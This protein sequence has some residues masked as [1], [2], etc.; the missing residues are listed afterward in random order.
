MRRWPDVLPTPSFPGFG[1]TPYDAV[2]R[3]DMEVG[4]ARVR[5]TT[6]AAADKIS[7][8]WIFSDAEMAAFRAWFEDKPVSVAGDS[9][10][11]RGWSKVEATITIA[12]ETGPDGCLATR[13]D[14]TAA[15]GG[16]RVSKSFPD[17]ARNTVAVVVW[18]SLAAAGSNFARIRWGDRDGVAKN[19]TINLA[20]GSIVDAGGVPVSVT[21]RGDGY[22]RV[23][24]DVSTGVGDGDPW[25]SLIVMADA[26]TESFGGSG[27]AIDVC[28]VMV[29]EQTG[30]DLF[31]RS[32]A[33]GRALGAAG[34]SAWVE[35]PIA[36]GGG[37]SF[38]ETRFV[39]PWSATGGAG[40]EWSVT[41]TVE[42]R[43][44]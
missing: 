27:C 7:C 29:R 22:W 1:L 4:L 2:L 35:M 10:D 36:T 37:F 20:T 32:G 34:G 8:A 43:N 11:L 38:V 30:F 3:T 12:P 25:L 33:D 23:R 42:S 14:Q 44:A 13:I 6:M 41:A 15:V 28:E 18:A 31:V 39:G 9:D 5:R 26:S 24:L 17:L 16:H 21:W 19:V 40:L